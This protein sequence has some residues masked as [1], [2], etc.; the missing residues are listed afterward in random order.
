MLRLAPLLLLI[1]L[2]TGCTH[3]VPAVQEVGRDAGAGV[4][5][6][7]GV[8]AGRFDETYWREGRLNFV[9][10]VRSPLIEPM[11]GKFRNI[12][13]PSVVSLPDGSF[14]VF[15]GGWDGVATGNDR[16]YSMAASADF[17]SLPDRR[18]VI[19]HGAFQHVCNVSAIRNDDGS[20]RLLC[21][22]YPDEKGL[23]KP[24]SFHL[25]PRS[26]DA[27][28]VATPADIIAIDDYP[29]YETGD[30]N[31]MNPILLD[32]D[33]R[34]IHLYFANFKDFGHIYHATSTNG[35][36]FEFDGLAV[37]F[38]GMPNDA[39]R[40]PTPDGP[41]TLL[42]IHRNGPT[43][44]YAMSRDG[45]H[46]D[47]VQVLAEHGSDAD[48]FIVAVG[49]VTRGESVLGFLYGAGN[50]PSLDRNRI[51]ARWLQRNVVFIT[52]DGRRLTTTTALGPDRALL[53]LSAPARGRLEIYAE[54]GITL[55]ASV[56]SVTLTPGSAYSLRR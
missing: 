15:Y 8:A 23:N 38:A 3:L 1:G 35:R 21:T 37:D 55:L 26:S 25:P 28:L 39:K 46:F 34:T 51:F 30:M 4:V 52:E 45:R 2:A 12:Y 14:R 29:A 54:D 43:L 32:E 20:Y 36:R 31:G 47:R 48:R 33:G 24:A 50:A 53:E 49:W 5:E 56:P 16:I 27:P 9:P 40:L 22:A 44:F 7:R 42:A 10:D 17:R 19:E 18:T 11:E 6:F 13:A 41:V